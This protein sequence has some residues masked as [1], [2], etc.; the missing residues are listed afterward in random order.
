MDAESI[1]KVL[2][3]FNFT[4]IYA[5]LMKLNTN[6]YLNKVFHFAKSWDVSHRVQ[7]GVNK[8]SL[9]MSQRISFLAQ[10]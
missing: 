1:P 2:K 5:I 9:N 4:A 6:M 3:I 10:L 7:E 8:K